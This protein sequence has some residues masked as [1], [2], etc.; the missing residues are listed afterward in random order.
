MAAKREHGVFVAHYNANF[1]AGES[2]MA[3]EQGLNA[4]ARPKL[5]SLAVASCFIS[6]TALANPT[7]PSVVNGTAAIQGLGTSLVQVTNSPSAIINWQSFSIGANE[8]T[9]F[10]QQ[11]QASAVLNRVIGSGGAIDPSVILGALQSNGRVFLIN[12]SGILFGA[13]AQIDVAGLVASSLNFSDADFLA[14]RLRFTDLPGAGSVVNQGNITTDSG[15]NVYLVG[16]AVTNDGI[17]TSPQGEVILAAGNSVELVEPG[18]PNLRVEINAPDNEA[19]NLGQIV[20]DSGRVGIYAGLINQSGTIRASSAVAQGGR[21][22]LKATKEVTLESSSILDASGAGGGRIEVLAK[23][24]GEVKIAGRLDASAPNSGDGG[25]IETSAAN[26]AVANG[27]IVTTAAPQGKSGTWLIDPINFTIAPGGENTISGI[28]ATTLS[29]NLAYGGVIIATAD[30][31]NEPGDINVNAAVSWNSGNSLTLLAHN[32]VFVDQP[33][34]NSGTGGIKLLAG[35]DGNEFPGVIPGSGDIFANAMV[36]T[37]GDIVFEAGRD[38]VVTGTTIHAGFG[39][40]DVDLSSFLHMKAAGN[41]SV[42]GATILLAD[43]NGAYGGDADIVLN[44]SGIMVGNGSSITANGGP[45]LSGTGGHAFI[46]V[47]A[48]AGGQIAMNGTMAATGGSGVTGGA[49]E[50]LLAGSEGTFECGTACLRLSSVSLS[51]FDTPAGNVQISGTLTAMGGSGTSVGGAA[52]IEIVANSVSANSGSISAISSASG[53]ADVSVVAGGNVI[54]GLLSAT[55]SVTVISSGG[56]IMDGNAGLNI[57]APFATMTAATGIGSIA[58]PIET[59][60]D[61]I[62]LASASGEIGVINNGSFNLNNLSFGGSA[63]A[64]YAS[65]QFGAASGMLTLGSDIGAAGSLSLLSDTGMTV[66]RNIFTGGDLVLDGGSGNLNVVPGADNTTIDS[67]GV[68]ILTGANV[69]I[70]QAGQTSHLSM[71]AGN[72]LGILT[73]GNVTVQGGDGGHTL[74]VGA[75]NLAIGAGGDVTVNGG[76]AGG[77]AHVIGSPDLIMEVGGSVQV[78][79]TDPAAPALIESASASTILLD[80]PLLPS[81]GFFVNGQENVVFDPA[82]ETGF[83]ADGQPAQVGTSLLVTYG[84]MP[85]PAPQPSLTVDNANQLMNSANNEIVNATNQQ[86]DITSGGKTTS[87]DPLEEENK[88]GFPICS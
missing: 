83:F 88:K 42:T 36:R 21:I 53:G 46:D 69:N 2:Q 5:L 57:A 18:T 79:A 58:D 15:G 47:F 39:G 77:F 64:V 16:S 12:P 81:G 48:G 29:D 84:E 75:N 70:G 4:V 49:G 11:S 20:A 9:R 78:N 32:D 50:I 27:T 86:T 54:L 30:S 73:P 44:A 35:W 26:V 63:A 7:G 6:S 17:I 13:G 40:S 45:N 23:D 61:N 72:G 80:F 60:V 24:A 34:T 1:S 68:T 41:I 62:V 74:V 19:R 67:A 14:N 33:I 22:L 43:G 38:I 85:T 71:F 3:M 10:I 52:S 76:S 37:G 65:T 87:G 51:G 59:Q 82:T 25:F 55:N 66:D 8:I 56:A 28:S 31:G